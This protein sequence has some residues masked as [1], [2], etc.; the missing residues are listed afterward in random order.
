MASQSNADHH[1][2]TRI[3]DASGA[4]AR[5][6]GARTEIIKRGCHRMVVA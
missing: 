6:N 5:Q 3:G 4:K 2:A 1:A